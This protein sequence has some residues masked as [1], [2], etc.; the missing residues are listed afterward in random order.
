MELKEVLLK[1]RSIRK[2]TDQQVE[3]GK[4]E[5][6]LRAAMCAPSACNRRPWEFYVVTNEDILRDLRGA[7][8]F[9]NMAAG[10][11]IVA[12]GNLKLALPG[13]MSPYWVQDLS[14]ATENLL[15]R[16]VDL[17]LGT[18]WCGVHPQ[19]RGEA[20]VRE[21]LGLDADTIPLNIIWVGYPAEEPNARGGYEAEK[22]HFLR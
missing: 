9:S 10:L 12:C 1:R 14:A 5:E 21:I 13:K 16:A 17:G 19:E 4:I 18:V 8:H 20:R 15:L 11:A 7:T 2:F 6:L 3:D 22:V